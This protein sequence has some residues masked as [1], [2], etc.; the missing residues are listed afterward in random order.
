MKK[1][2]T[3]AG[4]DTTGGAGLQ[5]DL[6]TFQEYGTFG[7]SA[8]TSIVTM[9]INDNWSHNIETIEPEVVGRQL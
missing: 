7:M 6:K 8:I 4:S 2:L 5:A 3:I 9:D 1:T